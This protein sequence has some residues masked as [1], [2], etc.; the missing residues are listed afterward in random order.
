[1]IENW[2]KHLDD[3]K[4]VGTIL[5]D[6]SKAFD[7][8][9]HDLLIEKLHVYGLSYYALNLIYTSL[10]NRKQAIKINNSISSH[11]EIVSGV[12]QGS[13]HGPILFNIFI[14]MLNIYI[15][16]QMTIHWKLMH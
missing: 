14:N 8:I 5:M 4:F 13:I 1:M 15:T 11:K 16:M 3:L 7:C 2:R 12:L 10:K 9:P 6:L